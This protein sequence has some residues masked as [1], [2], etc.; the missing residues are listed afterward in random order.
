MRTVAVG[1]CAALLAVAG[2]TSCEFAPGDPGAADVRFTIDA[3]AACTTPISPFV[4]GVNGDGATR[5]RTGATLLR[6]GGNRMTAYNWETN[7]SNAGSDW[8]YENDAYLSSSNSPAA[9]VTPMMDAASTAGAASLVTIPIVDRVAADKD[10]TA[11]VH[12]DWSTGSLRLVVDQ[13]NFAATRFKQN[14]PT[15]GA[16]FSLTPDATDGFVYQDE[17]VNWLK[18][19]RGSSAVLFSLDNEPDLWAS[20]HPEVHGTVSGGLLTGTPVTYAE[21]VQ[22]NT[23]YAKAIKDVWPQAAVTGVVSY[24]YNGYVS[25]QDAPDAGGR[26]FV[27]YYL[28]QMKA[29][30]AANGRRLVDVLDLHYYSEAQGGGQRVAGGDNSAAVAAAREQAP[31]SLWDPTYT[32]SSWITQWMTAGPMKLIP[33]LRQKIAEHYAGTNLGFTEWNFGGGNHISGA[34]ATADTLG[35]LGQQRVYLASYWA[36]GADESYAWAAFRA[37]RDYDGRGSTFGD[38]TC[39]STSSDVGTATAYASTSSADPSRSVIIAVNKATTAK[40]AGIAMSSTDV[41]NTKAQVFTITAGG[42]AAVVAQPDLDA[43]SANAFRYTM[44]AQSIS[45]I[46]PRG[47]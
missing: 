29:A 2:L 24:G 15:K 3:G 19:T 30:E 39:P 20:T 46:V 10:P 17:F 43:V 16:P 5:A 7:A 8:L 32:E 1:A 25:L 21:L 44:P 13:P 36:L 34:I 26:D 35:I 31:R 27:T 47:G 42:G 12:A 22:R 37:F 23:T 40:T 6:S 33:T 9:A 28:D 11:F 45:V 41:A 14:K 4:Y 18:T 38:R